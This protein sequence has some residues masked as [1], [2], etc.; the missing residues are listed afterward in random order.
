LEAWA[1]VFEAPS[2]EEMSLYDQPDPSSA[3]N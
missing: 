1:K 2:A 3:L